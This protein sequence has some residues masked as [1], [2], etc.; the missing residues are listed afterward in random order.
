MSSDVTSPISLSH[1]APTPENQDPTPASSATAAQPPASSLLHSTTEPVTTNDDLTPRVASASRLPKEDMNTTSMKFMVGIGVCVVVAGVATGWGIHRLRAGNQ[2]FTSSIP[3]GQGPSGE[4]TAVPE[5]NI[6]V[7]QVFGSEKTE[8]FKDTTEGV[9]QIGGI[10]G[11]GTH[12]LLR[13]G[14]VSQTVY[15]TSSVTDLDKFENAKVKIWGETMK[16][17]KA[18]WLIDVGRIEVVE[19]NAKAP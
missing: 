9:L 11:E 14:G 17:E 3:G 15:M 10:D 8:I 12:K 1:F 13:P 7:G 19:L 4:L 2:L 5:G 6:R 18:G 16:G